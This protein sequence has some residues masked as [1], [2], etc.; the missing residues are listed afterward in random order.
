M[1]YVNKRAQ[2]FLRQKTAKDKIIVKIRNVFRLYAQQNVLV[3]VEKHV[4]NIQHIFYFLILNLVKLNITLKLLV[5]KYYDSLKGNISALCRT[6]KK[7]FQ[8]QKIKTGIF[9][10]M[11]YCN[12]AT[13]L[14]RLK[15][16]T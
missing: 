4:D 12:V 10:L 14:Q 7:I 6:A 5:V 13:N 11:N 3:R 9:D 8:N 1:F 16:T 2:V 15:I